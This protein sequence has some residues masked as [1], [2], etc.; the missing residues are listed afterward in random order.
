M[1]ELCVRI[2][3][4]ELLSRSLCKGWLWNHTFKP[5]CEVHVVSGFILQCLTDPTSSQLCKLSPVIHANP[6]SAFADSSNK[7]T[8]KAAAYIQNFRSY[9]INLAKILW[10]QNYIRKNI[11]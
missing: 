2:N 9:M 11:I 7:G 8:S 4:Q 6:H 5:W 10:Q 1:N 3:K